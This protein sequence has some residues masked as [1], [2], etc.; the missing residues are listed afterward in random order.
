[1]IPDVLPFDLD[2]TLTDPK[3][4]IARCMRHTTD[5]LVAIIDRRRIG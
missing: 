1:V 2:G 4:G 3:L 5:G